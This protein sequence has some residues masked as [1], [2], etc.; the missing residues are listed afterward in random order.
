MLEI[1]MKVGPKGQVV[2]P[3]VFRKALKIFPRSEVIF[4]IES[5]KLILEKPRDDSI[6]IF[7]EIAKSAPLFTRRIH[8]HESHEEELEERLG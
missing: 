7:R 5:D 6:K 1:E 2:I 3:Q 8:P 4:K